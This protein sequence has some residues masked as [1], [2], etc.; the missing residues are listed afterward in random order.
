MAAPGTRPPEGTITT[1]C[2][3]AVPFCDQARALNPVI[4]IVHTKNWRWNLTRTHSRHNVGLNTQKESD[5]LE[6]F[7]RANLSERYTVLTDCYKAMKDRL[8]SGDTW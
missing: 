4:K 6:R 3:D 2:S 5:C 7:D 8:N 1:P